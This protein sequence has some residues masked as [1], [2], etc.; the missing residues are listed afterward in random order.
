MRDLI[1]FQG[2]NRHEVARVVI[3]DVN[4]YIRY[5]NLA[6][7]LPHVSCGAN[8]LLLRKADKRFT[9]LPS[10]FTEPLVRAASINS[11]VGYVYCSA[12]AVPFKTS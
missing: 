2:E 7:V 10:R 1:S 12:K 5:L 9:A 6:D 11:L 8:R 4:W 3:N